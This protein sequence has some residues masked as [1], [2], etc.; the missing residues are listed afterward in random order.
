M[1]AG[2]PVFFATAKHV[3]MHVILNDLYGLTATPAPGRSTVTDPTYRSRAL[4]GGGGCRRKPEG[5]RRRRTGG[6]TPPDSDRP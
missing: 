1:G 2:A 3:C 4:E 5:W 6:P